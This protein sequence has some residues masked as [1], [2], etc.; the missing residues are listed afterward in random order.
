MQTAIID[1]DALHFTAELYQAL[2]DGLGL[3]Q[4]VGEG[5]KRLN[6]GSGH[7]GVPTLYFQ[8]TE[9]FVFPALNNEVKAPRLWQKVAQIDDPER[10]RQTLTAILTLQ[11][12][13]A[14]ARKALKRVDD[15]T[16]AVRLYTDAEANYRQQ[17]WRET[18]LAL[19][20]VSISCPNSR[21]PR[22]LLA[23]VLGKL[24]QLYADSRP[25]RS[26]SPV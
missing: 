26:D 15:E 12:E 7:W 21:D 22:S 6:E 17:Q 5:R 3:E 13:H 10:R 8:G 1:T 24:D 19:E 4:A 16:L 18:Y 9:P 20:R 14:A 11:P 2:A 23:E 25:S